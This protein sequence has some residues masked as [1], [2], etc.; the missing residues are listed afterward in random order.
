MPMCNK[1]P[2]I[3]LVSIPSF[4]P[5]TT[6]YLKALHHPLPLPFQAPLQG[7]HHP[8]LPLQRLVLVVRAPQLLLLLVVHHAALDLVPLLS[9]MCL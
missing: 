7:L 3:A 2:L 8:N 9:S 5:C 1:I 4:C 6:T